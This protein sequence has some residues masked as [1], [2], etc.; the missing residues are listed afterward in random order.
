[1]NLFLMQ[2][3]VSKERAYLWER[4]R[5]RE[6][7]HFTRVRESD[8]DIELWF[9]YPVDFRKAVGIHTQTASETIDRLG[10]MVVKVAV[11][12][13][14]V[15]SSSGNEVAVISSSCNEVAV[16]MVAEISSS[17]NEVVAVFIVAVMK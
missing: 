7:E 4:E 8:W 13:V 12:I 17:C 11:L 15:K 2:I 3:I 14:A 10:I 6:K 9:C 16:L 5:E 1:M